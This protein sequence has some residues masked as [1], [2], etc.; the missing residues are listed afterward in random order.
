MEKEKTKEQLKDRISQLE[1][2]IADLEK[3]KLENAIWLEESPI[4]TK[5]LDV[6]FHLQ[7]MSSTGIRELQIEDITVYYGKPYPLSFYPDSFK[8]PMLNDLREAK[9]TGKTIVQEASIKNTKGETLWYHS[10]IVPIYDKNKQ[11]DHIM[12][13]S[14]NITSSKKA[15]GSLLLSEKRYHDLVYLAQEGI[16][17]IDKM[18]RTTFVNPAMCHMLGYTSEEMLGKSIFDF[19]DK[20]KIKMATEKVN[21][22]K[23]GIKEQHDFEFVCKNGDCIIVAIE[24]SPI[25][26]EAGNYDGAIAGIINIT[27]R[28]QAEKTLQQS[29]SVIRNKLKAIT[30][31]DGDIGLLELSDIINTDILYAIMND[32]YKITGLLG[33]VLD[34]KGN[35]LVAV[36]WKDI[37]TKF[38]RCNPE[39]L[40]NCI[41]SDTCLTKGV[42]EGTFKAYHCNNHMWDIAT[43]I[44]VGGKHLGN[45]FMGQYFL[46]GGVPDVA[47]FRAQAKEYGFD[48]EEYLAALEQVPT[49]SKE[50]IENGMQFYSKLAS[51]ISSLSFSSIKQSRLLSERKQAEKKRRAAEENLQNTFNISPSII[52]KAN[53][54]TGYFL[55]VN[56]AVTRILGYS[57][58]EFIAIPFIDLIH[59]DDRQSTQGVVSE[60]QKGKEVI[61]FENRYLCKDGTYKWITWHTTKANKEG[62]VIAIASDINDQKIIQQEIIETKQFYEKIIEGVQDGICVTEDKDTIYYA[63]SAMEKISEMP[64]EKIKGNNLFHFFREKTTREYTNPYEQAKKIKEPLWYDIKVSTPNHRDIWQNGWLIPQYQ[65]DTFLGMICTIRDITERKLAEGDVRM[66]SSA[67]QQSPSIVLIS[68]TDGIIEYVNPKF[69]EVTGFSSEEIIGKESNILRSGEHDPSFYEDLW[70]TLKAGKIWKGQFINKKKNGELFWEEAS[71][72]AILNESGEIINYIKIGQDIT[73]QRKI[74]IDLKIALEKALESDRL[75]S[76]FLANMSHE[77]RTPMNGILGFA[78]LLEQ[79]GLSGEEQQQYIRIIQEG[80]ARM[81][82][83]INDIISISMIESGQMQVKLQESNINE[84]IEYIYNSF[85]AEVEKKGMQLYFKNTLPLEQAVIQTDREKVF[86]ILTNLVKNAIKYS[87]TG[88]IEIGYTQ[89]EKCLELYVKDTGIGIPKERQEAIF[90]RFIQADIEDRMARQG[91]GLG[92]SISK[93]YVEILGRKIWVESAE[94]SASTENTGSTFYFTLPYPL[95]NKEETTTPVCRNSAFEEKSIQKLK[96]LIVEDDIISEELV[97]ILVQDFA[98]EI[99]VARTGKEA[100]EIYHNNPDIDLILMDI[101]LPEM[102]G[103]EASRQIRKLSKE[104]IIIAQ[105]AFTFAGDKKKV[106]E[107][108]CNAY[109]SKPINKTQLIGKIAKY[110]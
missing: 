63:N 26:D 61:F 69:M 57:V 92:L 84:Q 88:Y 54:K 109:V 68:D 2:K 46:E 10:T 97:S 76:A 23:R 18:N 1:A 36:G 100:V 103:Y 27:Q 49:F 93:A 20:S 91:A 3:T 45:V 4:C 55:E 37:C 51:L 101:Q 102:D 71:I 7:Y 110:F 53:I 72:S 25:I 77:I 99:L 31:P 11:L 47:L 6:D 105:T 38:H 70:T 62:I 83:I 35:V 8:I 60:Q 44:M 74:D 16:W 90:E 41:K 43:P 94:K 96:I 75:K 5:I 67:V 80:G 82:N 24:T 52:S 78:E 89:K 48:E 73:Q 22:R 30:E 33:A 95:E 15:E 56:Q 65:E 28:K 107:A 64:R 106:I 29:E 19:M 81:L 12:V 59:P 39:T 87:E 34:I 32:F 21:R 98:K 40:K 13:V 17:V 86:A 108:G 104:V 50:T 9:A 42:P 85:R 58:D 79:P 14:S 66:L